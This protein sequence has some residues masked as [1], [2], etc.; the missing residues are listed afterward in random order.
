M[1]RVVFNTM[2]IVLASIFA[3]VIAYSLDFSFY[4]SCGI[5]TILTIQSTKKDTLHTA[6]ERF[7]AFI[8]ALVIAYGCFYFF[9]YTILAYCIYLVFYLFICQLC[10][11]YSSMAV[12]SVLISHFLTFQMMT[13]P[14]IINELGLFGIGVSIGIMANLHLKKNIYIEDLKSQADDQIR[15]ILLRM[16]KRIV[17][18]ID[19]YDGSCFDLLYE[20]ISKAKTMSY[21][22]EKNSIFTFDDFD[23]KYISMRSK[24]TQVLYEMYKIIRNMHTTP[25]TAKMISEFLNKIANE[26]HLKNDCEQLLDEF[27]DLDAKMKSTPLPVERNEFEDRARLFVLLRR[28]E[29]FLLIKRE[30]YKNV[31]SL[32]KKEK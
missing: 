27:Y 5:V 3:I 8:I 6:I 23:R 25:F 7:M 29:E 11:W 21:E 12:N 2:K 16:S 10:S 28:I 9:G 1:K 19:E 15:Y 4:I 26:Y 22:N 17:Q 20:L 32:N 13:F 14:T 24:Q 31:Y 30:F 18:D